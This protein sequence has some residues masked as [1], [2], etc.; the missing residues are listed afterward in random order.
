MAKQ[1]FISYR[2]E[3]PEHSRAVRR[4]GELLRQ[5]RI[6]VAL[7]QFY[8][9]EFPGGPDVGWPK[10]CEECADGSDCLLIIGSA[11]WFSAY[12][13]ND[14]PGIGLGAA[15][16][17][18]IIRQKIYD[19]QG[20]NT[21]IRLAFL[22]DYAP[23]LIPSRLKPWHNYYPFRTNVQLEQM[24]R[25]IAE[26]LGLTDFD[27]PTVHWPAPVEF[28]PDMADRIHE[29]WPAIVN[30]LA[31]RS[32]ERVLLLQGKSGLGKSELVRQS[33]AYATKLGI[34]S[35]RVDFKGGGLELSSVIG[36]F[37]LDLGEL[38]PNFSRAGGDKTHLLRKD[39]R[40]LRR[41][42]LVIF[43]SYEDTIDN[44]AVTDWLNQQ[45]LI[46]VE[47]ALGLAVIIAGQQV[48]EIIHAGWRD[49]ARHL[50]LAP[51]SDCKHWEQWV[52]RRFPTIH[53]L[54]ADL[55]TIVMAA[56]GNP[57][58]LSNLCESIVKGR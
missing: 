25:W 58:I 50:P 30:L 36:Q 4:L 3:S 18:D 42:V 56:Q 11:G 55:H 6:P 8:L 34:K 1:V 27:M 35:V 39:L 49:L 54:G 51:I 7:D 41:P 12:E 14:P 33:M 43:D 2:Q 21:H 9:D 38:L 31:G 26:C 5:A 46:E 19:T 48:P 53:D 28:Q 32:R 15:S 16:E 17:A 57:A 10:W 44:K 29:E 20:R 13:K 45:F 37:D 40:A 22:H 24:V 52:G 23:E 47:T